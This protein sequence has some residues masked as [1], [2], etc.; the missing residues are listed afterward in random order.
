MLFVVIDLFVV[1]FLAE[2]PKQVKISLL[3]EA[4]SHPEGIGF[5]HFARDT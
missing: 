2:I 5:L 4:L 1:S 3:T